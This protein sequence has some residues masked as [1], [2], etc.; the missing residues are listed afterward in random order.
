MDQIIVSYSIIN[1]TTFPSNI[2]DVEYTSL[3][4][5]VHK[6]T[7]DANLPFSAQLT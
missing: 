7:R 4:N 3:T 2:D 5:Y 6:V 1:R